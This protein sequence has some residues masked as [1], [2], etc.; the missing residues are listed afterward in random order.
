MNAKR[1]I[2]AAAILLSANIAAGQDSRGGPALFATL[3]K[4]EEAGQSVSNS[5]QGR[6]NIQLNV[7]LLSSYGVET[8]V[9]TRAVGTNVGGD[10]FLGSIGYSYWFQEDLAFGVSVGSVASDVRTSISGSGVTAETSSVVPILIGV[11][12]QPLAMRLS[13]SVRPHLFAA[14]GPCI[15]SGTETR[16]GVDFGNTTFMETALSAHFGLG[17]DFQI[18]RLFM[19]G[20]SVGY[21]LTTDFD[22]PVAGQEN[23]RSPEF[24]L[25]MGILLGSGK[26]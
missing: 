21:F 19:T 14:V 13:E 17:V 8:E 16:A 9:S 23:Y 4:S 10:G 2:L 6:H 11:K 15:A 22:R 24:S 18:S 5:R 26:K 3:D 20:L 7:G 1:V 12:Y 25:S